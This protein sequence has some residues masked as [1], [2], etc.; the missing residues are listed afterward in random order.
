MFK[1][2]SYIASFFVC[3]LSLGC[4]VKGALPAFRKPVYPDKNLKEIVVYGHYYPEN[5]NALKE[6]KKELLENERCTPQFITVPNP[7]I[8]KCPDKHKPCDTSERTIRISGRCE[9]PSLKVGETLEEAL[10]NRF[11]NVGKE[12]FDYSRYREYC[13]NETDREDKESVL[14]KNVLARLYDREGRLLS[15]DFLRWRWEFDLESQSIISYL[16]YHDEG[17][18]FRVVRLKGKRETVL[19]ETEIYTQEELR[20][21]SYVQ[22]HITE[23]DGWVYNEE[24]ECH[25]AAFD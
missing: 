15:E 11:S 10:K 22:N 6:L 9:Y 19:Y 18:K 4:P 2:V 24:R 17:Y 7:N 1:K 12:G 23:R 16:P 21:F 14:D 20:E 3:V 13:Y 25:I 5:K 8:G